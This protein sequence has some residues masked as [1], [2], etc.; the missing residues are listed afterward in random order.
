MQYRASE[1]YSYGSKAKSKGGRPLIGSDLFTFNY[2]KRKAKERQH[3]ARATS[4]SAKSGRSKTRIFDL[5]E[6]SS[7]TTLLGPRPGWAKL[8]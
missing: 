7:I 8:C 1:S 6:S 2:E 4:H 3:V 5:I